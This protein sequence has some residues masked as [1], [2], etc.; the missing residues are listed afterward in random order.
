MKKISV[1]IPVYNVEKYLNKCV[2][3][4]VAQTY[5]NLQIILVDDGS[6]DGSSKICDAYAEADSRITVVH[7]QNGGLSSARNEGMKIAD[8]DY[9]T[10]LD[11]D[12]YVSPTA[13]EELY[14]LIENSTSDTIACTCFRRVDEAGNVMERKDP[15][16]TPG[17]TS[18]IGYLRELLLHIGDVSVCTKLFPR[19]L[20]EDRHFDE[21][22]LNEDLLF[23]TGFISS[24]QTIAYTGTVG[25]YYLVRNNSTSSGY[26]KAVEDMAPNAVAV[27]KIVQQQYPELSEEGNRFAL[28]QNMAYLLLVPKNLRTKSNEKYLAALR[29]LRS[30]FFKFGITNRYLGVK[31]KLIIFALILCPSFAIKLFQR[32]HRK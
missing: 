21:N 3:S 7:K 5:Q 11:S 10:F 24:F 26:G 27:N 14:K 20:L 17:V 29:Y 19:K 31:N 18:G 12:D 15:H 32:K 9:V 16:S 23:M 13:Y 28:F 22:R 30:N 2:D 4:V 1:I 25:Y 8:G 6:T